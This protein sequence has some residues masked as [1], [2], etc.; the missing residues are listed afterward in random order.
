MVV[1][2]FKLAVSTDPVDMWTFAGRRKKMQLPKIWFCSE[3]QTHKQKPSMSNV[4]WR[5]NCSELI[6]DFYRRSCFADA[7]T[8]DAQRL[9][10]DCRSVTTR[11]ISWD[12]RITI[13]SK[14]SLVTESWP[15]SHY[16][17]C[18]EETEYLAIRTNVEKMTQMYL[19]SLKFNDLFILKH[20]YSLPSPY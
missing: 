2:W 6:F 3:H 13:R 5:Q 4:T 19:N 16:K 7:V 12:L 10:V 15:Y 1:Q 20:T 18:S 8:T 9:W 17:N 11:W 14:Y